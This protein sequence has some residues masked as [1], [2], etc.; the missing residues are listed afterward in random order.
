GGLPG[1]GDEPALAAAIREANEEIRATGALKVRPETEA[2]VRNR[3]ELTGSTEDPK[4]VSGAVPA[5]RIVGPFEDTDERGL[6]A[7]FPPDADSDF[8]AVYPVKFG[9]AGWRVRPTTCGVV[10]FTAVYG[11]HT[12]LHNTV[13]YAACEVT[14]PVEQTVQ[15]RLHTDD[16]AWVRLNDE[17]VY[18][19]EGTRGL[20]YDKD[21]VTVTLP[22]G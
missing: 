1:W 10:S 5:W 8:D 19:F 12:E 18:R 6:D 15:M 7:A 17:E 2:M 3:L 16:D 22:A 14:S 11:P 13:A 4:S 21:A 9:R 20:D